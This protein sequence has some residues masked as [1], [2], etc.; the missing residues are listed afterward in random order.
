MLSTPQSF[1]LPDLAA[2]STLNVPADSPSSR[3]DFPCPTCDADDPS[4]A[5]QQKEKEA[6]TRARWEA[7]GYEVRPD[8]FPIVPGL[9]A[10]DC[11]SYSPECRFTYRDTFLGWDFLVDLE[12]ARSIGV[13]IAS[14]WDV[15]ERALLQSL[16]L[17]GDDLV[18]AFSRVL[19]LNRS[20]CSLKSPTVRARRPAKVRLPFRRRRRTV[21]A[22][23]PAQ[24]RSLSMESQRLPGRLAR[25]S[26]SSPPRR[27]YARIGPRPPDP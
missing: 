11:K 13:D 19:Q 16:N 23:D 27:I 21:S 18:S 2:D 9:T 5:A 12:K 26:A 25:A 1:D 17:R 4:L 14:R 10:E 24:Q 7:M 6:E 3:Q 22:D 15:R 8:G 20:S